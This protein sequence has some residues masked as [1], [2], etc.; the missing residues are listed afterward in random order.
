M[1]R[2]SLVRLLPPLAA[3]L[4]LISAAPAAA[5][6]PNVRVY[7]VKFLCGS[8][9]SHGAP[10]Y[11]AVEPGNYGTIINITNLTFTSFSVNLN[12]SATV[13]G[14]DG[15]ALPN[16]TLQPGQVSTVDC[17]AIAQALAGHGGFQ[18]DGRFVEGYVLL[19]HYINQIDPA[20]LSLDVT[21]AYSYSGLKADTG[22]S[23]QVVHI[24]PR[25]MFQPE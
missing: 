13:Q 4:A 3:L 5:Q 16:V 19:T 18:A 21:A 6:T 22:A 17:A 20:V 12:Q 15:V 2:N 10:A 1:A 24:E 8:A 23:L 14:M 9:D 7:A 25:A 11:R